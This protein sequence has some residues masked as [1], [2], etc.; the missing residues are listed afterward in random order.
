MDVIADLI[1]ADWVGIAGSI[2]IAS[3]YFGVSAGR[4]VG[5]QPPFQLANLL[6]AGL[7]LI[8]LYYRPNAGA[9]VIEVLWVLIAIYSLL[10]HYRG[11]RR[12]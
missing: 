12:G 5:D 2:V 10:R 4:L 11:R 3:A 9:I 8:S 7:I 1:W 6:G